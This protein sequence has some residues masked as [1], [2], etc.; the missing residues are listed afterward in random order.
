MLGR[1]FSSHA[2]ACKLYDANNRHQFEVGHGVRALFRQGEGVSCR[3]IYFV[4]VASGTHRRVR[5][6]IHVHAW[7]ELPLLEVR[8]ALNA[9][10][11]CRVGAEWGKRDKGFYF[12][13]E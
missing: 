1:C 2:P 6:V 5:V 4:Y 8:T 9:G 12:L 7:E 3:Q 10:S 11:T 13:F